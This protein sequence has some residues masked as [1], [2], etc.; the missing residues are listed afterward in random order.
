MFKEIA[1]RLVVEWK[2]P[3]NQVLNAMAAV[4]IDCSVET[5]GQ[6]ETA[7]LFRRFAD[8]IENTT[9]NR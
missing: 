3:K 2:V 1:D 8:E 7:A 9:P 5:Y 6:D 4:L